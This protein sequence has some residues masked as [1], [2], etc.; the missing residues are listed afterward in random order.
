MNVLRRPWLMALFGLVVG[1]FSGAA[2]GAFA[3]LLLDAAPAQLPA[4]R[5]AE[6]YDIEVVVEEAYIRRVMVQTADEMVGAISLAGGTIDLRAG[7]VA[8]FAVEIRVGPLTPVIEGSVGFRATD[9]GTSVEVLLLDAV[10]GHLRLTGLIPGSVLDGVNADIR[11]LLAD[12]FGAQGLRVLEVRSDDTTL[13]LYLGR[14][15]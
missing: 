13:R 2:A 4:T 1:G 8:D 14:E 3:L 12:R 6:V 15:G 9:D 11:Q 7:G 10:M 5:P